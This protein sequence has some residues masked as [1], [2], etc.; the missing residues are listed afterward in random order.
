MHS[1]SMR[2]ELVT[3]M[4]CL[5]PTLPVLYQRAFRSSLSLGGAMF[6]SQDP[7]KC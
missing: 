3:H 1:I 7:L 2:W 5:D 6:V 4:H